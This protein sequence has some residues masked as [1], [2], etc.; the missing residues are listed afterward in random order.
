[1]PEVLPIP[2]AL[3]VDEEPFDDEEIDELAQAAPGAIAHPDDPF[4]Q[5]VDSPVARWRITDRSSAEWA[6][7]K[8][9]TL[10]VELEG[11]EEQASE[12]RQ[13][14]DAWFDRAS[15]IVRQRRAF[16]EAH[17]GLYALAERARDEKHNKTIALPS[18]KVGTRHDPARVQIG[19]KAALVEWAKA[20]HPEVLK[21]DVGVTEL[22]SLAKIVERVTRVKLVLACGCVY[23]VPSDVMA[24]DLPLVGSL[25]ECPDD[26]GTLVGQ[27]EIVA[28]HP[29]VR[30][31]DGE[32]IPG[33][34]VGNSDTTFT[35]S[36]AR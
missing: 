15:R 8:F 6:M 20:H 35:V 11:L 3:L 4:L 5:Q 22:R 14:I 26:G 21:Y 7:A 18:G 28:S 34:T 30:D 12:W 25:W 23:E 24:D 32:P 19:D 13:R 33:A 36:P 16:F 9:A 10:T 2:P 29:E 31:V 17:L 1:M 27:V